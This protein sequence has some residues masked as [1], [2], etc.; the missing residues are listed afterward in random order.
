MTGAHM[1]VECVFCSIVAGEVRA[2]VV[3]ATD[4]VLA[5]RD[6]APQAPVHVIVVPREH[7]ADV[8][9]LAAVDPAVLGELVEVANE[10]AEREGNGEYRLVFNTGPD[11]GQSVFHAHGHVLAGRRLGWPPG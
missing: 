11:A 9:A 2:D 3:V 10:G 6:V 1:T 7:H 5:F 4:R 8:G